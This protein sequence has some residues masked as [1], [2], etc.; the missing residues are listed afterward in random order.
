MF[1]SPPSKGRAQVEFYHRL[2][3]GSNCE[4]HG[5]EAKGSQVL[6]PLV[7]LRAGKASTS[8]AE[9][10]LRISAPAAAAGDSRGRTGHDQG[11]VVLRFASA[12]PF[13]NT[14]VDFLGERVQRVP[15][16]SPNYLNQPAVTK[17]VFKIIYAFG[18]AVGKSNQ[19]V[20]RLESHLRLAK[21]YRRNEAQRRASRVQA[22]NFSLSEKNRRGMPCIRINQPACAGIIQGVEAGR[23]FLLW[24]ILK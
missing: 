2:G 24:R 21:R 23:V 15:V 9:T 14:P 10:S 13:I 6:A 8:A 5:H 19:R 22:D 3:V 12:R 16:S 18:E 20:S 7:S 17:L 1:H 11:H 4:A